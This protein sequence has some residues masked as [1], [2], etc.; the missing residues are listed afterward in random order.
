MKRDSGTCGTLTKDL[1]LRSIEFQ[2]E[3]RKGV[4]LKK[5]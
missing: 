3:R 5:Y 1:I 2:E 4:E